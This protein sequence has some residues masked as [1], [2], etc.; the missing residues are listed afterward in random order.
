MTKKFHKPTAEFAANSHANRAKYEEMYAASL[1]DPESF[2]AEQGR[3]L[4]W[5]EPYTC[6]LYTSDAADE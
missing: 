3:R 5:I 1:R 2:W 6:L 4:D